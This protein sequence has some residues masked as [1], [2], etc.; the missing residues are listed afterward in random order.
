[1][2]S[3]GRTDTKY[4]DWNVGS[5]RDD[6]SCC[7]RTS[8]V[9]RMV[10]RSRKE[11]EAKLLECAL[12][13]MDREGV[14]S[15]LNL[16][17]VADDA[18]LN[19]GLVYHYFGSRRALLRAALRKEARRRLAR[20][21]A[22]TQLELVER[23]RGLLQ[24]SIREGVAIRLIT[25]LLLDSAEEVT[26]MPLRAKSVMAWKRDQAK[27]T[28]R[29]DIDAGAFHGIVVS[30]MWGYSMLRQSLAS[31]FEMDVQ[32]LDRRVQDVFL[33]M[34]SPERSSVGSTTTSHNVEA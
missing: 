10:T 21:S 24:V 4:W 32:E 1:M 29:N 22:G 3:R 30:L 19:R 7:V 14:L 8:L 16:R 26:I 5:S 34:V 23:I 12:H 33:T 13:R 15:G 25:L 28:L 9:V 6:R 27:G 20:I 31:E 2:V 11:T 18:G 17:Q